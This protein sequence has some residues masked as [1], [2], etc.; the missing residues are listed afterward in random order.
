[1][2]PLR[3]QCG[4]ALLLLLLLLLLFLNVLVKCGTSLLLLVL[5]LL[6]RLIKHARR[7]GYVTYYYYIIVI[8]HAYVGTTE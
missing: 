6:P 8:K 1:V 5:L 3:W 4:T 7:M 2:A